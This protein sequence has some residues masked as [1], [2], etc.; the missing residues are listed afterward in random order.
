MLG[1]ILAAF[2]NGDWW[3]LLDTVGFPVTA[4]IVLIVFAKQVL[5]YL[6][7]KDEKRDVEYS[8]MV[9]EHVVLLERTIVAIERSNDEI[10]DLIEL[11]KVRPCI[12][13]R[14]GSSGIRDA[15]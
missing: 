14:S 12:V 1:V 15:G 7:A 11:L 2:E 4:C 5:S 10:K 9:K 8:A 3:R 13:G 6:R